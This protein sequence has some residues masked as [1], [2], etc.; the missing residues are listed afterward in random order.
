MQAE[1]KTIHVHINLNYIIEY[2]ISNQ[3]YTKFYVFTL[4]FFYMYVLFSNLATISINPL[5]Y[6]LTYLLVKVVNDLSMQEI[7]SAF[8]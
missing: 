4:L 1:L 7:S 2:C 8:L 3:S 5:T 6:L